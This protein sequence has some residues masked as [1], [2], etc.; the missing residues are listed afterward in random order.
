[1]YKRVPLNYDYTVQFNGL[2]KF[3]TMYCNTH[4]HNIGIIMLN[5]KWHLL[6][7]V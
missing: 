7:L 3:R 5:Y 6:Q 1:M 4:V 2:S